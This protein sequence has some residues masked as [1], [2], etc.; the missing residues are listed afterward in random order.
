MPK[1][2]P[3]SSSSSSPQPSEIERR[4]IAFL[5]HVD[6]KPTGALPEPTMRKLSEIFYE[7]TMPGGQP[8]QAITNRLEEG[9]ITGTH[10]RQ[11]LDAERTAQQWLAQG[12]PPQVPTQPV[13][14][15]AAHQQAAAGA[16]APQPSDDI[17]GRLPGA[18]KAHLENYSSTPLTRSQSERT[19]SNKTTNDDT[20]QTSRSAPS[21]PR[22]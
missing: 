10:Q 15:Q 2:E 16:N 12:G 6:Q 7:Q 1:K 4:T 18:A 20:D 11:Y 14:P 9:K 5:D 3:A 21:S 17:Y 13:Q 8:S 22:R 19:N